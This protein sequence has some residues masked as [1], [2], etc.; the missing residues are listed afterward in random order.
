MWYTSP[1]LPYRLKQ[2]EGARLWFECR[3][4]CAQNSIKPSDYI[5]IYMKCLLEFNKK[6]KKRKDELQYQQNHH[7]I[8]SIEMMI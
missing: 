3:I 5:Y 7:H 6:K 8:S 1:H 4:D 2:G